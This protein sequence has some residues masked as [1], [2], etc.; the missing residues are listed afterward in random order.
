MKQLAALPLL[1][2][3][4]PAL[5][6]GADA[7]NTLQ[8]GVYACELPGDA[9]GPAGIPVPGEDF[10]VINASSY[11]TATGRGAYLLTGDNV[12]MTSGPKR[13]DRYVRQSSGFL[14][15]LDASGKPGDLRCIQRGR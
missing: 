2:L 6:V 13:G 1:L 4:A 10:T 12:V 9:A 7:L 5:A 15:K 3:A 14:R 8:L 11:T